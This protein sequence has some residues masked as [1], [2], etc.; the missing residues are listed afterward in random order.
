M[1]ARLIVVRINLLSLHRLLEDFE[2]LHLDCVHALLDLQHCASPASRIIDDL[3]L[4]LVEVLICSK[5][6]FG[7]RS[8]SLL[9]LRI[10]IIPVLVDLSSEP[11]STRSWSSALDSP[12]RSSRTSYMVPQN[13]REVP[14]LS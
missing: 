5:N 4:S 11:P 1:F 10:Q 2:R 6:R 14:A 7:I 12:S 8:R 13:C 9:V 3:L